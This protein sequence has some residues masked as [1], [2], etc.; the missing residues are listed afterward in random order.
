MSEPASKRTIATVSAALITITMGVA[1]GIYVV[2]REPDTEDPRRF[3]VDWPDGSVPTGDVRCVWTTALVSPEMLATY[4]ARSDAGPQY[5]YAYLC[6][7][8]QADGGPSDEDELPPLPGIEA[9][10]FDQ[11]EEPFD[12]GHPRLTAILQGAP[13]WPCACSTG[14]DCEWKPW[15]S[16]G[17]WLEAPTGITL[18]QGQWRGEGCHGKSCVELGGTSS[19]PTECPP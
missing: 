14:S 1:A 6:E 4:G 9:M 5:A 3:S 13:G 11:L 12:G 16:G 15:Y 8:M 17:Q 18:S 19:W 10:E 2:N 7:P